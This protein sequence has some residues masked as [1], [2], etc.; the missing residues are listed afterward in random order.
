MD[1]YRDGEL[2]LYGYVGAPYWDEGFTAVQVLAALAEHGRDQDIV[3]RLNSGGGI[4]DEAV[5]IFNALSAHKGDV[6][7][8][9]DAV[10]ASAASIIAMAGN[11]VVMKAGSLMMIHDPLNMTFGNS[12]DHAKTIEQ[13]EAYATQ[14]AGIY[15]DRTG[16]TPDAMRLIM[17]EEDWLTASEAVEQGFADEA[18]TSKAKAAASF[19]YRIYQHAPQRLVALAKRKNWHLP[20]AIAPAASAAPTGRTEENSMTDKERAD[21]LAAELAEIKAKAK[22][23]ADDLAKLRAE[24][25]DRERQD[26]ILALPEAKGREATAKALA[27]TAGMTAESAKAVLVTAKADADDG[28]D[29]T[30]DDVPTRVL[31]GAGLGSK[32]GGKTQA[33]PLR[34]DI[35]AEMKRRNGVKS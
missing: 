1:I 17:K 27:A 11:T 10:A 4:V 28:S 26:A 25:A 18:E 2:W 14:M 8:E 9:I 19:D 24:N 16:K 22:V 15:A 6:R 30:A 23:D 35:V 31:N 12:A 3:V 7:M 34:V 29:D 21:Q 33:K 32:P 13:L 5:A 20:D